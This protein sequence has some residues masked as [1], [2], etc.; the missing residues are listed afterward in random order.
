MFPLIW[1]AQ[2]KICQIIIFVK[3]D[4]SNSSAESD[5]EN[6]DSEEIRQN[7]LLA[8][9]ASQ[10]RHSVDSLPKAVDAL[11][12]DPVRD[13]RKYNQRYNLLMERISAINQV[14]DTSI[15][16]TFVW[17]TLSVTA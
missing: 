11:P 6:S 16:Q 8:A 15:T 4:S 3:T 17:R 12:K 5:A 13:A 2:R 10:V 1:L 9:A 7:N 14:L